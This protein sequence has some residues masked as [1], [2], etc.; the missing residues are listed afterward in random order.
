MKTPSPLPQSNDEF[1][2]GDKLSCTPVQIPI[3]QTHTKETWM[4][5]KGYRDNRDGTVGCIFCSWGTFLPG[6]MRMINGVIVDL[7]TL[8]KS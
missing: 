3:C 4:T 8:N 1:W 6:Y 5:H 7:R 2:D